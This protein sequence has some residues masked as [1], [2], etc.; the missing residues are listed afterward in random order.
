MIE[1]LVEVLEEEVDRPFHVSTINPCVSSCQDALKHF[2]SQIKAQ[3]KG[4][5][6]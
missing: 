6:I 1:D 3:L 5:K 2:A 4:A